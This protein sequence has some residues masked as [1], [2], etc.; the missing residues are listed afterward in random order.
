[1]ILN[2]F[3]NFIFVNKNNIVCNTLVPVR[4]PLR[5]EALEL[6]L[7]FL[8]DHKRRLNRLELLESLHLSAPAGGMVLT[9][10]VALSL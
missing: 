2:S 4:L 7:V 5:V 6:Q 3:L 10:G 1:M 8:C 9:P